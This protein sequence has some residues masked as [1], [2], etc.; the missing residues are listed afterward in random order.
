MVAKEIAA[1]RKGDLWAGMYFRG[2][3]FTGEFVCIAPQSG[4]FRWHFWD[5]GPPFASDAE[6]GRVQDVD[7]ILH[8]APASPPDEDG[9]YR[10]SNDFIPVTW[11][12]RR[13][14]IPPDQIE[15]FCRA[16]AQ[17]EEPRTH[18]LGEWLLRWGD[19]KLAPES[20]DA[21]RPSSLCR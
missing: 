20:I 13:Y 3:G 18:V 7:G 14:L 10:P 17:G 1:A 21:I 4:F 12:E 11:G 9:A 5:A 2:D 15:A 16:I 19:E 6:R 8:L